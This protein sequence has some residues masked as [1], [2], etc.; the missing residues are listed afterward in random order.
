MRRLFFPVCASLGAAL[1]LVAPAAADDSVLGRTVEAGYT[2]A[3]YA[4]VANVYAQNYCMRVE[5]Q[6]TGGACF[7]LQ[8]SERYVEVKVTDETGAP[9][10]GRILLRGR[11]DRLFCGATEG[12]V[13][14]PA[15]Q[16]EV[17]IALGFGGCGP[18]TAVIPTQGV[19][20]A[21]FSR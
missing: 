21:T 13:H 18:D 20:T 1:L 7:G 6:N 19:I 4:E 2:G 5:E 12:P 3:G 11:P 10:A 8:K 17:S 15:R 9:V 16:R 14:L